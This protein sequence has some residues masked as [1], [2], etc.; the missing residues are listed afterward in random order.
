MVCRYINNV[1]FH[2]FL[3][4]VRGCFIIPEENCGGGGGDGDQVF[5]NNKNIFSSY[6]RSLSDSW[7]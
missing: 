1:G 5:V 3:I 2:Y 7:P 4:V 6:I